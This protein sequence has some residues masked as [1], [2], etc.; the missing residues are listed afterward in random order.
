MA[1]IYRKYNLNKNYFDS[2]DT[3]D[4]AYWLGFIYA[5]GCVDKSHKQLIIS[6]SPIDY[7]HLSLFN[8]CIESDY[9]IKY[10]DNNR[11]ITL[12]IS[13]K[14]LVESLIEKGCVPHKSLILTFPNKNTIPEHLIKHFIRGYFD[15]DG[16]ISTILRRK[17]NRINPIMECEVNFLGTKS[18][19]EGISENIPI[20][21]IK[22]FKF[23]KIYKFRVQSKKNIINLMDYLYED[24][25]FYLQR[26]YDKYINN[27]KQYITK[28]HPLINNTI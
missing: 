20:S 5:D 2:I 6:L 25:S 22:I 23:G 18:M 7:E 11:Y 26:K 3:E 4:K 14:H 9:S 19:L 15:G 8:H 1:T 10:R 12:Q 16:C 17:T 27:V 24:S 21:S 13:C 28:R